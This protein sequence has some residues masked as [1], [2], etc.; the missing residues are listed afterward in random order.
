MFLFL[1]SLIIINTRVHKCLLNLHAH[2]THSQ[3]VWITAHNP[4]LL[5]SLHYT[6]HDC[7]KALLKLLDHNTHS[8]CVLQ[9]DEDP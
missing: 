6:T 2:N 8:Q 5:E 3:G 7:S 9:G 4:I 1:N